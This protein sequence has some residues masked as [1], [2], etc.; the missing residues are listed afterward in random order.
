MPL[1]MTRPRTPRIMATA[2]SKGAP[3]PSCRARESAAMPLP[4][5]SSVRSADA[6]AGL[7]G[8]T[9]LASIRRLWGGL[10]SHC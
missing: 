6:I 9:L 5:A 2:A 4:S 7:S 10:K 8:L 1:T 3:S